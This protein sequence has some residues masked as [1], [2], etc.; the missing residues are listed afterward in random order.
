MP[1]N[2][3]R[4]AVED[5]VP[6][7]SEE[8]EAGVQVYIRVC[9]IYAYVLVYHIE[10]VLYRI[11]EMLFWAC[12]CYIWCIYAYIY[13]YTYI[14]SDAHPYIYIYLWAM[15]ISIYVY[16]YIYIYICTYRAMLTHTYISIYGTSYTERP[17]PLLIRKYEGICMYGYIH[18]CIDMSM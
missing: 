15:Y 12:M 16:M 3:R 6:P 13:V 1:K 5:F 14:Q 17:E 18:I 2:K 7:S 11:E 10:C 9:T 4:D 8:A